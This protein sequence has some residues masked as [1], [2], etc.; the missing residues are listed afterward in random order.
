MGEYERPP[1]DGEKIGHSSVTSRPF[2][3]YLYR[4]I[5]SGSCD[6]WLMWQPWSKSSQPSAGVAFSSLCKYLCVD[7]KTLYSLRKNSLFSN[8]EFSWDHNTTTY[9][10][11]PELI[12][13][14]RQFPSPFKWRPQKGSSC[15]KD[16]PYPRIVPSVNDRFRERGR[17]MGG[18]KYLFDARHD[19]W[20][21]REKETK[22][23]E[24]WIFKSALS[25]K[26]DQSVGVREAAW[27]SLASSFGGAEPWRWLSDIMLTLCFTSAVKIKCN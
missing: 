18:K 14:A 24:N 23:T 15:R 5:I 2:C 16:L 3:H 8:V 9:S 20:I 7:F 4:A 1:V 10:Q 27:L 25:Q 17:K 19:K 11:T 22:H 21:D 6:L 13:S 12:P 26:N